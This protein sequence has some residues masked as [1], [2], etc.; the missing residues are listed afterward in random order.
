[1]LSQCKNTEAKGAVSDETTIALNDSPAA[2]CYVFLL[3]RA[4]ASA[5]PPDLT[6]RAKLI[7]LLQPLANH[8]LL[9]H[10]PSSSWVITQTDAAR[11]KHSNEQWGECGGEANTFCCSMTVKMRRDSGCEIDNGMKRRKGA[12]RRRG[13]LLPLYVSIV[14]TGF[15]Y[16]SLS[17]SNPL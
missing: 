3:S 10:S 6:G 2:C 16:H 11:Q 13:I 9:T 1:M 15:S 4:P 12:R 5:P 8:S 7:T 17:L 14:C